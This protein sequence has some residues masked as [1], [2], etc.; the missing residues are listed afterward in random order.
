MLSSASA[1]YSL[2]KFPLFATCAFFLSSPSSITL[3][4]HLHSHSPNPNS[5][6]DAVASLN[7]M[8]NMR[9]PPSRRHINKILGSIVKMKQ[10]PHVIS[11]LA[12]AEYKG[13]T[14]DLVNLSILINCYGHV[15]QMD[16]A[17]STFGKIFKMG[18]QPNA[19]IL[20]TLVKGLCFNQNVGQALDFYDDILAKGFRLNEVTY[21]ALINGLCKIGKTR[22]AIKL[23]QRMEKKSVSRW[24]R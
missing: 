17:F 22:S 2:S 10:Y 13:F 23:L 21:G 6:K 14:P 16:F 18:Y 24:G 3:K 19:V 11:L 4:C 7:R 1:R 15:G 5:L 9:P 12:Q 20:T 8:L